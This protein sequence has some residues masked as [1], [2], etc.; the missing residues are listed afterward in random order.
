MSPPK[1]LQQPGKKFLFFFF[2]QKLCLESKVCSP[3]ASFHHSNGCLFSRCRFQL[4][5]PTP[6]SCQH[7][8]QCSCRARSRAH[9]YSRSSTVLAGSHWCRPAGQADGQRWQRNHLHCQFHAAE[10]AAVREAQEA[11]WYNC[12]AATPCSALP[13]SE[14]PHPEGLHKHR[15][16]EISFMLWDGRGVPWICTRGGGDRGLTCTM[17]T[18][19]VD[20][21]WWC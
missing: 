6:S 14:E 19:S 10:A 8:C 13:D 9:P 4:W 1:F 12:H 17:G 18:S 16:M 11:G 20:L 15:W 2:P 21:Y 7:E 5:E 3:C